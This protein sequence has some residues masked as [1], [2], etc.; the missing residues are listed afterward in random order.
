MRK[1]SVVVAVAVLGAMALTSAVPGQAAT[2]AKEYQVLY[3]DG[4]SA[5][6]ARAA[7][8]AIGGTVLDENLAVGI[9]TVR[10][11][12]ANFAAD[13]RT[14]K[15]LFGA[16]QALRPIGVAPKSVVKEAKLERGGPVGKSAPKD[17]EGA[18]E[19]DE[20][21]LSGLQWGNEM[22]DAT[23]EGSYSVQQGHRGVIAVVIDTGIDATHPDLKENFSAELSRNFTRDIPLVDGPCEDEPDG[24]CNDPA[25][26]DEN[27]HGT[28][29]AGIMGAAL[30]GLGVAGV[31]PK[32]TLVNSRAGQDSGY[33]F[34]RPVV[35]AITHAADIGADVVNMSFY[36][37]P[38]L[39]NC[40][41]NPEDSPEDQQEQQTII[42]AHFR[43]MEYAHRRGVTMVS[44]IGNSHVNLDNPTRDPTSPDF[45]P[46]E[47]YV[48][49]VDNSCLDLPTEG[50]H[51]LSVTSL[52]PS[53]RKSYFSNFGLEQAFVAAPGGDRREY[54]GTPQY[55][56]PENRILSSYPRRVLAEAHLIDANGIPVTPLVIRNCAGGRCAYYAYLQGTSMAGPYAAG[57]VA[58]I[59]AEHGSPD[60]AHPGGVT[61]SPDEVAERLAASAVDH[62]CPRPRLYTYPDLPDVYDAYCEG[63]PEHNGFYGFGIVNALN[64]VSG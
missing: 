57:V 29:V 30:N 24:S 2:A 61:L 48:R 9:A 17:A 39:Y 14:Q 1:L 53:G 23:D 44:S 18:P 64:A 7:I 13:V 50:P 47:N 37:D 62:P 8:K 56:A 31:A 43:V 22:I 12:N 60:P 38:W 11:R 51:A 27:G 35:D 40:P 16:A 63:P 15:A 59:V 42:N 49:K 10:T 3:A 6:Q 36:T 54:Y 5:A 34:L 28:H 25:T 33:F 45:P 21:P 58:L 46:G 19:T 20:D 4:A 26:V 52:G 41:N 32:V 55:N